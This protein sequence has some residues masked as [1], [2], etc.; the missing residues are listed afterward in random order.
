MFINEENAVFFLKE[1]GYFIKVLNFIFLPKICFIHNA[2]RK[3][4]FFNYLTPKWKI[5][6]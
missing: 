2:K 3:F 6:A 4:A 5:M 1:E